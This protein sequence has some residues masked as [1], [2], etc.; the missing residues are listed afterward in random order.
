MILHKVSVTNLYYMNGLI[1]V[2]IF[3]YCTCMVL[4]LKYLIALKLFEHE[5]YINQWIYYEI[6]FVSTIF[7]WKIYKCI[8]LLYKEIVDYLII[9]ISCVNRCQYFIRR[10]DM[11]KLRNLNSIIILLSVYEDLS[12]MCR[13]FCKKFVP[14]A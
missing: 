8:F 5:K 9:L 4:W 1:L 7:A 11:N 3:A 14:S 13:S 12:N 2:I 10:L 6:Q